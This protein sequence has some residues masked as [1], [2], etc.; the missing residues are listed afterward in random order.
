MLTKFRLPLEN[1]K[2]TYV[3][4]KAVFNEFV[5]IHIIDRLK[6]KASVSII[7]TIVE[8]QEQL[9]EKMG[10][11]D[12]IL[13]FLRE[14]KWILY[15]KDGEIF[16]YSY[17]ELIEMSHFHPLVDQEL[18]EVVMDR[19]IADPAEEDLNQLSLF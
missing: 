16:E 9:L 7:E 18:G 19:R 4:V 2:Y 1:K 15:G 14:T 17:G 10:V 6:P 12:S 11:T 3:E 5:E 13:P 8:V